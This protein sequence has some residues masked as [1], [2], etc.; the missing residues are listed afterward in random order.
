[1]AFCASARPARPPCA[2]PPG[3]LQSV[4]HGPE[5]RPAAP[6]TTRSRGGSFMSADARRA[7]VQAIVGKRPVQTRTPYQEEPLQESF[8]RNVFGDREMRERLPETAYKS[9]RAIAETGSSL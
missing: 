9:L 7:A 2:C 8:G 3:S 5:A 6:S 4:H 1:M